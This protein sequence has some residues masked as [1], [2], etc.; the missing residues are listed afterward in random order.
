MEKP[1]VI[2]FFPCP[3][4][5]GATW[6]DIWRGTIRERI[7][8]MLN[9]L[10]CGGLVKSVKIDDGLTGQCIEVAVGSLFTK[11]TVNGRDYYF[12]RLTGA[13]DGTGIGCSASNQPSC[14]RLDPVPGSGRPPVHPSRSSRHLT[15]RS[16]V[17]S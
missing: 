13:F 15:T 4:T 3:T 6:W 16:G 17:L 1:S 10:G 5:D 8:A 12:R 7:G 14:C 9:R 2:K 11:I